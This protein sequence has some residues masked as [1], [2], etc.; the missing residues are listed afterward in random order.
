MSQGTFCPLRGAG[1]HRKKPNH[2]RCCI[3][4]FHSEPP[5]LDIALVGSALT[6]ASLLRCCGALPEPQLTTG[7]PLLPWSATAPTTS[8]AFTPRRC[9]VSPVAHHVAWSYPLHYL[10]FTQAAVP[11]LVAG[12]RCRREDAAAPPPFHRLTGAALP[13]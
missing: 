7:A 2:R 10:K 9:S 12:S 11:H 13:W 6:I 8:T 4:P 5:P 3:P 1:A